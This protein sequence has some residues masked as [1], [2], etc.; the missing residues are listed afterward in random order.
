MIFNKNLSN[1]QSLPTSS[2]F[3]SPD[4]AYDNSEAFRSGSFFIW[5]Y[6]MIRYQI[7][8]DNI[9]LQLS[10]GS[11][12]LILNQRS[13][14]HYHIPMTQRPWGVESVLIQ[15]FQTKPV[16]EIQSCSSTVRIPKHWLEF[17]LTWRRRT[18]SR[19]TL[20]G[21]EIILQILSDSNQSIR[22]NRIGIV[23]T[24]YCVLFFVM[25]FYEIF[26]LFNIEMLYRLNMVILNLYFKLTLLKLHW[27]SN[28]THV[29]NKSSLK[30][31]IRKLLE[32]ILSKLKLWLI[33]SHSVNKFSFSTQKLPNI[34]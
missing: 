16:S 1:Q 21:A 15:S 22:L 13:Y 11:L 18:A 14:A 19:Q 28:T 4:P 3:R 31:L 17:S 30:P 34:P 32:R 29:D 26:I 2:T 10:K 25:S 23:L 20:L 6:F 24:Y 7:S 9:S 8:P 12:I 27:F 33:I 5:K